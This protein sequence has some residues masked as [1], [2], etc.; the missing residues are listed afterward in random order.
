MEARNHYH[1]VFEHPEQNDVWEASQH[2][3]PNV[4]IDHP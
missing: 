3:F 1:F 2:R 4:A